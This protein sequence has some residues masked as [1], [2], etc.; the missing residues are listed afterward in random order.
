MSTLV[1]TTLQF[2]SLSQRAEGHCAFNSLTL[3]RGTLCIALASTLLIYSGYLR[4]KDK[5]SLLKHLAL[6]NLLLILSFEDNDK[7]PF[8]TDPIDKD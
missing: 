8:F 4:V 3:C 2:Y 5:N 7:T 1:S 6:G